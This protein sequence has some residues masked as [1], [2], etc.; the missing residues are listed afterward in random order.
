MIKNINMPNG[1]RYMSDY[2]NLLNNILP[3][4]DKFI[5]NKTITGCGG[6]SMF[7]DS[8]LDVVIISPRLPVLK[9]K[10]RQYQ[11]SFLFHVPLCNNRQKEISHKMGELKMYLDSHCY[12]T[13]AYSLQAL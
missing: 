11:E 3:L 8:N 7:L 10:S 9:V 13:P 6:T 4:H 1:C 5:L 12:N 2:P